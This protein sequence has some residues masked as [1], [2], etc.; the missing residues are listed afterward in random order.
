MTKLWNLT[1]AKERR[2]QFLQPT[3]V[4]S[5]SKGRAKIMCKQSQ[6]ND[7]TAWERETEASPSAC[8]LVTK[9]HE[10]NQLHINPVNYMS[11]GFVPGGKECI[12]QN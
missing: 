9:R 7:N 4:I 2:P 6:S 12:P 3:S 8:R 10:E 1:E 11:L 5:E